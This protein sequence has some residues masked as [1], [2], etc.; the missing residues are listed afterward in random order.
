MSK[1][2]NSALQM[3]QTRPKRTEL[4]PTPPPSPNPTNQPQTEE[5]SKPPTTKPRRAITT[6]TTQPASKTMTTT[7]VSLCRVTLYALDVINVKM[8]SKQK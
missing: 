2:E 1:L 5:P 3:G 4:S 7:A 8:I 6:C